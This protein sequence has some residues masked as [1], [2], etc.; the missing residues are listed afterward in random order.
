MTRT[1]KARGVG[2]TA[3][4]QEQGSE[5]VQIVGVGDAR[6]NPPPCC[7]GCEKPFTAARKIRMR[8]RI[9][10]FGFEGRASASLVE[11][12]GPCSCFVGSGRRPFDLPGLA[13]RMQQLEQ[14]T[15]ADRTG[16]LQ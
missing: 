7:A 10:F 11:L 5:R 8:T 9:A 15:L 1:E 4:P 6:H 2:R 12:C 13:R 14:L 3:G 16:A